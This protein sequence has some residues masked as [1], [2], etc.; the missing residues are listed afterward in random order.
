MSTDP[1]LG[2][3]TGPAVGRR[4][5]NR[6][7]GVGCML[8]L[9]VV[10]APA[11]WI[12]GGVLARALPHWQWSVITTGARGVGGGLASEIA[13][14]L[15]LVAG[16]GVIAGVIG[17]LTG[18]YLAEYGDT[19]RFAALLRGG[20]E[21]LAGIPSIVLGYVGYIAF[22]VAFGWGFSLGAGLIVLSVMVI[23][24]IAKTTEVAL[25]Q[26]PTSY[27]EGAEALGMPPLYTMRRI[28]LRAALPGIV[29][30][31][32]LALAIAVGET[33]PL[34]YTAGFS[35]SLPKAQLTHSPVGYLTYA[36]YTFFNEPSKTAQNLSYDAA[37]LLVVLVLVLI[38]IARLVVARTQR[39]SEA[40]R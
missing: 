14:T 36:V 10:V 13:G 5:S 25:R 38:L 28:A 16:V 19:V 35:S 27:R 22:V 12:V 20:S 24:Y 30:G 39:H 1:L 17:V 21:V 4:L 31:I 11:V 32:I 15:V 37:L 40:R 6:V 33:A 8:A 26:V 23:P 3:D 18:V 29:T 34:L 7:Y 2:I 9:L